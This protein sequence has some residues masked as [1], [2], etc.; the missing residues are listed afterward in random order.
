MPIALSSKTTVSYHVL[1]FRL[2][3]NKRSYNRLCH[4]DDPKAVTVVVIMVWVIRRNDGPKGCSK[5][6]AT[7][8]RRTYVHE[9]F[10]R[11]GIACS[12]GTG[13]YNSVAQWKTWPS[14]W[15]ISTED[16]PDRTLLCHKAACVTT[17]GVAAHC[18][19][20]SFPADFQGVV[21]TV[22]IELNRHRINVY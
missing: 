18:M 4:V 10:H 19:M 17:L 11:S 7:W 15:A 22:G 1:A 13:F 12:L 21:V 2:Q 16:H 3:E 5:H 20:T 8:F 14:N 9:I 6:V